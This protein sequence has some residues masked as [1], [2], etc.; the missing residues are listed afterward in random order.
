MSSSSQQSGW[1]FSE[2]TGSSSR[3]RLLEYLAE[4]SGPARQFQI[5][6]DLELSQAS[7]SRAASDLIETGAVY[8]SD[9]GGLN[10]DANVGRGI[11]VIQGEL[12][13]GLT[14]N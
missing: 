6:E 3:T 13:D 5:A 12:P 9:D 2:L 7:V 4:N 11:R 10:V 8:R 1:S 14:S